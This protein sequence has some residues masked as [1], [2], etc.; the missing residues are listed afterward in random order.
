MDPASDAEEL[1]E[2]EELQVVVQW[3]G[4]ATAHRKGD[5]YSAKSVYLPIWIDQGDA[6]MMFEATRPNRTRS[7]KVKGPVS[8]YCGVVPLCTVVLDG[9]QLNAQGRLTA[10]SNGRI[11]TSTST[12]TGRRHPAQQQQAQA[13]TSLL[14][15]AA[16]AARQAPNLSAH[17]FPPF[18]AAPPGQL[19]CIKLS[20]FVKFQV[21]FKC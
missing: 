19:L 21:L 16:S 7:S 4:N 6:T 13:Q 1:H 14:P 5:A 15:S 8:R 2:V 18:A 3:F 17:A 10:E 20:N 11:R 9:M 12:S